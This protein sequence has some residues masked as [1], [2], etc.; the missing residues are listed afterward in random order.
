MAVWWRAIMLKDRNGYAVC[1]PGIHSKGDSFENSDVY[2]GVSAKPRGPQP[3]YLEGMA[4]HGRAWNT[5]A[6]WNAGRGAVLRLCKM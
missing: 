1:L 3:S 4:R 6:P 2:L 5:V